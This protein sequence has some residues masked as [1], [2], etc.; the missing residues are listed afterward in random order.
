DA[1]LYFLA[2]DSPVPVETTCKFHVNG[3][4]PELWNPETG[5][6]LPSAMYEQ[7][8]SGVNVPL[9]FEPSGSVFVVFRS[10]AQASFDPIVSFTRSG[11]SV[12]GLPQ[13][14]DI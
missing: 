10:H 11:V 8:D 6:I 1:E 5:E 4:Q 3:L 9:R 7:T 12:F 13:T 2:S 14:P